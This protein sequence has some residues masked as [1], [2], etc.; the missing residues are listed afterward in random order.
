MRIHRKVWI[1]WGQYWA[2]QIYLNWYFSLGVHVDLRRPYADFHIGMLIVS[3]GDNP[4][5]TNHADTHRGS[6]RGF[7]A[8][9]VL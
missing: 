1:W 3:V 9:P 4:A 6:C 5:I 7:F 2:V 8:E